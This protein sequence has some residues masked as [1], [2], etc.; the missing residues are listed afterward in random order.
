[1]CL[2][3]IHKQ[4]RPYIADEDDV[5]MNDSEMTARWKVETVSNKPVQSTDEIGANRL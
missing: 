1:V 2:V 4:S 3:N 5:T